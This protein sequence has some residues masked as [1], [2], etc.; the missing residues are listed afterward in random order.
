MKKKKKEVVCEIC[1]KANYKHLFFSKGFE[2][3]KCQ[4]CKL[5]KT[6]RKTP[7]SY[8]DYHSIS[9]CKK[10]EEFRRNIFT[11]RFNIISRYFKEPGR[12]LDIG[13]AA[14]IMLEIFKQN[15]W[16][17]RG[18]EPSQGAISARHKGIKVIQKPFESTNFPKR[19]FDVV[20]LNHTL[21]H[22]E[23]PLAALVK[24]RKVL[25]KKGLVFIDVP[26]FGG[27]SASILGKRWWYLAP[28]EHNYHF[29][30]DTLKKL[31][32]KSGFKVIYSKT[33]SGIFDYAYPVKELWESFVGFK[34]RFFYNI[35]GLP[36]ALFTTAINRGTSLIMIGE[37]K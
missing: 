15:G 24:V 11:K 8:K 10:L 9:D 33:H 30:P 28:E 6:L 2:L 3:L 16:K 35:L 34:K 19:Y 21:E 5:V 22:M 36:G 23:N 13:A 4:S 26:N 37:K 18:V 7:I 25:K 1:K 20:I 32:V 29:T 31:I 17:V 14:G 12:V 27:L